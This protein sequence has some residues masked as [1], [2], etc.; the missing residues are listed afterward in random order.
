MTALS[1]DIKQYRVG[2]VEA[3]N[4]LKMGS[5]VTVY[6]NSIALT[7]SDGLGKSA[8]TPTSNDTCWGLWNGQVNS[9]PTTVSP[10][11]S[12]TTGS[13][14][15]GVDCGT[16]LLTN[17]TSGDALV[18]SDVGKNCYVI[19]EQTVGKLNGGSR[20]VAGVVEA[21]SIGPSGLPTVAVKMGSNQSSG[22]PG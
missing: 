5:T 8:V 15:F 12:G 7:G 9:Q 6:V 21:L 1:K 11:V 10:L 20:P 3:P 22:G 2:P 18:Q 17:G 14:F 4:A 13:D 16:F 19:D